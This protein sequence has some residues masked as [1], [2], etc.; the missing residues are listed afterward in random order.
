MEKFSAE[1]QDHVKKI[2]DEQVQQDTELSKF[3][4]ELTN[5]Y[6]KIDLKMNMSDGTQIWTEFGKY[7]RHDDLVNLYNIVNPEIAKFEQKI[8]DFST[9]YEKMKQIIAKFDQDLMRK[10]NKH[11]ISVLYDFIDKNLAH[12]SIT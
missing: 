5:I 7:S 2:S 12:K 1:L 9:E 4:A 11:Q 8:I 10:S 6:P 3:G